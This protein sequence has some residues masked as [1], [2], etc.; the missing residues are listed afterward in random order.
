MNVKQTIIFRGDLNMRKGK[1]AAQCAHAATAFLT[2]QF[3]EAMSGKWHEPATAPLQVNVELSVEQQEW[4]R[5]KFTKICL[6]VDTEQDLQALHKRAIDAGL[7]SHLIVDAGLTE[8]AG[9]PTLTC[10]GIGPHENS[11]IDAITAGLKPY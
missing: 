7:T 4:I 5:G 6:V 11:R 1:V 3:M 9:V 10:I 2:R 8:F